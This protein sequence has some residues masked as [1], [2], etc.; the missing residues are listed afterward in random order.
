[1]K[2]DFPPRDEE[3]EARIDNEVMV[4][5]YTEEEQALGWY[6][7]IEKH[8][9]PPFRARCIAASDVSPLREGEEV[10][11]IGMATDYMQGVFVIIPWDG[12]TLGVPLAQLT[13]VDVDD[14]TAQAIADW[15]YWL[16]QGGH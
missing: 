12:R 9:H 15:H 2:P 8:L 14:D 1:M 11:V 13:G 7:Y 4:D 10:T 3:R 5:A 6:Y 16:G